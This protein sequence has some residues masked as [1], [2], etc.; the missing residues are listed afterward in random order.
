MALLSL[1]RL[2]AL[3]AKQ[4]AKETVA[5]SLASLHNGSLNL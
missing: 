5:T 3:L 1:N 2:K 4:T